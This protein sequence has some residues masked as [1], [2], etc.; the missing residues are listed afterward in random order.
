MSLVTQAGTREGVA[1]WGPQSPSGGVSPQG[2]Q[3]AGLSWGTSAQMPRTALCTAEEPRH[4]RGSPMVVPA[5]AQAPTLPWIGKAL[6]WPCSSVMATIWDCVAPDKKWPCCPWVEDAG[7][8]P[9]PAAPSRGGGPGAWGGASTDP[10]NSGSQPHTPRTP[11]SLP[12]PQCLGRPG[13]PW[14]AQS[15]APATQPPAREEPARPFPWA[16][17]AVTGSRERIHQITL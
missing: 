15:P 8:L 2:L 1:G 14:V 17:Q 4:L 9:L 7:S 12:I 10:R 16:G 13:S 3:G 11:T 6:P 5:T